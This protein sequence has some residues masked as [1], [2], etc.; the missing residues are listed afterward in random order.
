[1]LSTLR[2]RYVCGYR[3]IIGEPYAG[4]SGTHEP[5]GTAIDTTNGAGPHNIQIFVMNADGIVLHCLAG[6]WN[7]EDLVAELDLAERLNR[8]WDDRSILP[9]QKLALFKKMQ[10]DHIQDHKPEMVARSQLQSFD[11]RFEVEK[12]L[13]SSDA[14]A[15]ASL[16]D[17]RDAHASV[18]DE[19][20]KTTDR[21]MH[22]RISTRPFV[23][24][25]DFDVA[26][27][28]DYGTRFYDKNENNLDEYGQVIDPEARMPTIRS[29]SR[30]WTQQP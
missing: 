4:D 20:F 21:L 13:A 23:H 29:E 3:N 19:A 17:S 8:V 26:R 6:Y 12:R 18:P 16:I 5:S 24:Y 15:D 25:E 14:I 7:S 2:N 22:E 27:F 28:A 1:M 11:K 30:R 9:D 10:L